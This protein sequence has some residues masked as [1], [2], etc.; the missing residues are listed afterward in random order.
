MGNQH[1]GVPKELVLRLAQ[2][3]DIRC[4]VE[5]GT[6]R[7]ETALWAADH[8]E[9]VITIEL[10]AFMHA[11]SARA[12]EGRPNVELLQGDSRTHLARLAPALPPSIVWLDAHWSE[13]ST[14]GE[15]DQCPTPA[16]LAALHPCWERAFIILDDA[17]LFLAPPPFSYES[18]Q[19]PDLPETIA[20]LDQGE[21]RFVASFEDVLVSM[22]GQA[23][24][25]VSEYLHDAE[26]MRAAESKFAGRGA[27]RLRFKRPVVLF[28]RAL[29]H[30]PFLFDAQERLLWFLRDRFDWPRLQFDIAF[31][32][33]RYIGNTDDVIDSNV[34]Y[35]GAFEWWVV[36]LL[37]DLVQ[38]LAAVSGKPVLYDIGAN[39]G[40]HSLYVANGVKRIYAFEPYEPALEK[41]RQRIARNGLSHIEL[42][43]IGLG[44]TEGEANYYAPATTNRGTGSFLAATTRMN[45]RTPIRLPIAQGDRLVEERQLLPP[46]IIKLD[47]EGSEK[48]VLRG[49][50]KT[51][52]AH[53]PVIL[54]ELS[55]SA[56]W[57]FGDE[58]GLRAALY[59]GCVLLEVARRKPRRGYR[60]R[61][62]DFA[63][64]QQFLCFPREHAAALGLERFLTN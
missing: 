4:F 19:W 60:L 37:D 32:G 58:A 18:G 28:C 12:L 48:L 7:A 52:R 45:S 53:R 1:P 29:G 57:L 55:S 3:L 10:S 21:G 44:D 13:R 27:W 33:H 31:R 39:T 36:M 23:R 20:Q 6:H 59:P 51:I 14:A 22:P 54:G 40:H 41:F 34:Y 49:L 16:E 56:R 47:V 38:R 24:P 25:V 8:F 17:H 50:G 30:L 15:Q 61:R 46:D 62:F 42:L 43:P 35:F 64:A 5:T 9:R 11:I 2:A 63:T 26:K